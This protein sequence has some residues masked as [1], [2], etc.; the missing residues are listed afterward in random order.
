M[1]VEPKLPPKWEWHPNNGRDDVQIKYVALG[2]VF[3]GRDRIR[4]HAEFKEDDTPEGCAK[5]A[6]ETWERLSGMTQEECLDAQRRKDTEAWY[7]VRWKTLHALFKEA[8]PELF[9]R[10]CDIMANGSEMYVPPTY[11]QQFYWLKFEK[12]KL[13]KW[14][15]KFRDEHPQ[16]IDDEMRADMA[17]K[18]DELLKGKS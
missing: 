18:L 12:E 11:D 9:K 13:E 7:A 10:A 14:L 15:I 5:V 8:D 1:R 2:P 16:F 6:W 3:N 17:D 4:A